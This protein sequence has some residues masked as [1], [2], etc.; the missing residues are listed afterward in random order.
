MQLHLRT[1]ASV[2]NLGMADWLILHLSQGLKSKKRYSRTSSVLNVSTLE[3]GRKLPSDAVIAAN[4][5]QISVVPGG[6]YIYGA[7]VDNCV[8]HRPTNQT[9]PPKLI[10]A[11]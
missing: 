8:H 6:T 4:T 2:E 3:K 9:L 1:Y 11:R 7:A 10:R 5:K